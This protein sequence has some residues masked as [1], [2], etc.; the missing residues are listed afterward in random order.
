MRSL[1]RNIITII[2]FRPALRFRRAY[3]T[4]QEPFTRS[5]VFRNYNTGHNANSYHDT[6]IYLQQHL[7][8]GGPVVGQVPWAR[9]SDTLGVRTMQLS[10]CHVRS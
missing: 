1:I 10:Q 6:T 5:D 8:A 4:Q 2:F 9:G 3:V 7:W